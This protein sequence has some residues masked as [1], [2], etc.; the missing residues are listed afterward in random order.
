MRSVVK[1]RRVTLAAVASLVLCVA[2]AGLWVRGYRTHDWV[3]RT[4]DGVVTLTVCTFPRQVDLGLGTMWGMDR[5][6]GWGH[7][8]GPASRPR[9]FEFS[10]YPAL[11]GWPGWGFSFPTWFPCVLFAIAPTC[12]L[13]AHRRRARREKLGHCPRCGYDLRDA[14]AVSGVWNDAASPPGCNRRSSA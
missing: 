12:W 8:S 7:Q 11:G 13:G 6:D 1:R 2:A 4:S 10:R 5:A 9:S 14:A 3:Y